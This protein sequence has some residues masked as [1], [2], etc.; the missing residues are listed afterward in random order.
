MIKWSYISDWLRKGM[1]RD[2][3]VYIGLEGVWL[4]TIRYVTLAENGMVRDEVFDV[5]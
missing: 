4:E 1:L 2:H 3:L 5:G